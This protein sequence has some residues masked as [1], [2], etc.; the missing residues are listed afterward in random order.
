MTEPTLWDEIYI[1]IPSA[2]NLN[3]LSNIQHIYRYYYIIIY[4]KTTDM[5]ISTYSY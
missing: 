2:E 3:L 4:N 1:Y 5:L